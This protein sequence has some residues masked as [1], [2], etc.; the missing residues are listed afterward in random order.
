MTDDTLIST[1]MFPAGPKRI[2][3]CDRD[4]LLF[5]IRYLGREVESLRTSAHRVHEMHETFAKARQTHAAS[6]GR[7]PQGTGW[8][9]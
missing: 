6:M 3:D 4:E 8:F 7:P 2:E 5:V 1:F 9:S